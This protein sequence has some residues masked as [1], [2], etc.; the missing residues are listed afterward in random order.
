MAGKQFYGFVKMSHV[1]RG[2]KFKAYLDSVPAIAAEI[3]I[4]EMRQEG[5]EPLMI[6]FD[7]DPTTGD[8]RVWGA[9]VHG[10]RGWGK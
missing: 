9:A 6:L 3:L 8:V 4:D 2:D 1:P 10:Y 7:D 5:D